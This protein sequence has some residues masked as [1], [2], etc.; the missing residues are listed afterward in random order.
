MTLGEYEPFMMKMADVFQFV[1]AALI[2]L[3]PPIFASDTALG[4][5]CDLT[6]VGTTDKETFVRF[7][8]ELRTA[9]GRGDVAAMA[10]LVRFPLRINFSDGSTILLGNVEALQTRFAVAFPSPVRSAILDQK[11]NN[12]ICNYQGIMYGRGQVWVEPVDTSGKG[13]YRVIAINMP[14]AGSSQ[15]VH[16]VA[17]LRFVCDTERYR[18]V[19]DTNSSGRLR[20]RAW[21]QPR[22][23]TDKPDTEIEPGIESGEGTGGCARRIWKFKKGAIEFNVAETG[24]TDGSEPKGTTGEL[25]VLS[26][27]QVEQRWWCR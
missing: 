3:A 20:Y 8:N 5:S 15:R 7:H 4:P 11:L 24:C 6:I 9:I 2:L 21:N 10:L 12:I 16:N 17:G 14:P 1:F 19:I 26:E 22:A 23:V 13:R 25:E 18:I 27:G